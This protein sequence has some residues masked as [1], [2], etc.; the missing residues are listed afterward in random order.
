MISIFANVSASSMSGA[1]CRAA[2]NQPGQ[3]EDIF[4]SV[5]GKAHS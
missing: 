5:S 4:A 1:K 2:R 3:I